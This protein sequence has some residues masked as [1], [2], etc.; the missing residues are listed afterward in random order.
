M[1]RATP[2]FAHAVKQHLFDLICLLGKGRQLYFGPVSE[3][4]NHFAERG[5]PFPKDFNPADVL[6]ELASDPPGDLLSSQTT[7]HDVAP[8]LSVSSLPTPTKWPTEASTSA[9]KLPTLGRIK[10]ESS[11]ASV[12]ISSQSVPRS[13]SP[14]TTMLTQFQVLSGRELVNLKRDWSLVFMHNA[15]AAILGIFV[16]GPCSCSTV[17]IWVG[18]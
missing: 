13:L 10:G 14:V 6:L 17:P 2:W 8:L 11:T 15:V 16:G 3:A 18:D 1:G 7:T 4:A 5:L 12:Q 9:S